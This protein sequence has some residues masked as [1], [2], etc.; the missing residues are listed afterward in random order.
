MT[1]GL[2]FQR[3]VA[4]GDSISIDEYPGLDWQEQKGLRAP[5]SGLGAASLLYRNADEVWPDF[6]GADLETL[7]PDLHFDSLPVD[8]AVTRHVL[9]RQLPQ[10]GRGDRRST[11]VTL[12]AGGNDLLQLLRPAADAPGR[13]DADRILGTID[14]ILRRLERLFPDRTVLLGTVYDPSDG[15]PWLMGVPLSPANRGILERLNEGIRALARRREGI[16]LTDIAERFAG[17]GLSA[18][19]AEQWYWQHMIIEPSAR[20][21]SEVRRL[22]LEALSVTRPADAVVSVCCHYKVGE[23]R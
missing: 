8:A 16:L 3:Y 20:G 14:T 13:E 10:L 6:R 7:C 1:A 4:L 15:V 21:A 19:S 18:P 23:G 2:S 9:D 11:L 17:H 12:T 5:V 22:W